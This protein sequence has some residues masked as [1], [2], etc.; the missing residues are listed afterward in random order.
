MRCWRASQRPG[1]SPAEVRWRIERLSF[2]LQIESRIE[3]LVIVAAEAISKPW[4][5]DTR[6]AP[7]L[8]AGGYFGA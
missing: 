7:A 8:A 5:A 2:L 6:P 3:A 4:L 1:M